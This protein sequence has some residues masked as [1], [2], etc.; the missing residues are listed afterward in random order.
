MLAALPST[1]FFFTPSVPST[2]DERR[3]SLGL[4]KPKAGD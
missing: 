1:S 3:I 4:V 2:P